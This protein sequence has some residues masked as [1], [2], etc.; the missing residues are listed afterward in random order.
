MTGCLMFQS[1][2][3]DT[4]YNGGAGSRREARDHVMDCVVHQLSPP[5][6]HLLQRPQET[7]R[8]T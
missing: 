6:Y 1:D 4:G 8:T 5:G 7:L 2:L 3:S